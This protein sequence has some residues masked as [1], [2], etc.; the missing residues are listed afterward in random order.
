MPILATAWL[1]K[2]GFIERFADLYDVPLWFDATMVSFYH[3]EQPTAAKHFYYKEDNA[4]NIEKNFMLFL[5]ILHH[6]QDREYT[7]PERNK[8]DSNRRD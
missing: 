1:Y 3:N 4:A 5:V 8:S 6:I 7:R 2:Y